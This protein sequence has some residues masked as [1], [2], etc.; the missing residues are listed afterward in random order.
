MSDSGVP[1]VGSQ[2]RDGWIGAFVRNPVLGKLVLLLLI[3]GGLVVSMRIPIQ[4]LPEVDSRVV[5]IL[6][7]YPGAMPTEVETDI[8][9]RLETS[10]LAVPGVRGVTSVASEGMAMVYAD[11]EPFINADEVR[12]DIRTAVERIEN[13]PP[14]FAERPEIR[15][16][17]PESLVLTLAIVSDDLD[18]ASLRIVAENLRSEILNLPSVDVA[19]VAAKDRQITIEISEEQ[20]KKYR[21]SIRHIASVINDSSLDLSS[22]ELRTDAG[23]LVLRTQASRLTG[24]EFEDI[25]LYSNEDGSVVKIGDVAQII[26]GFVDRPIASTLD[27]RISVGKSCIKERRTSRRSRRR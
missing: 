19:F 25:V 10:L 23:G 9:R 13:F 20:L 16:Q 5:E 7:P 18:Y 12:Y 3:V 1:N 21:T 24:E 8:N 14:P 27:G 4:S 15:L 11:I 6:V 26:D 17:K 2:S 22:G